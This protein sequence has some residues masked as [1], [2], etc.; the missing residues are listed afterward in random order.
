LPPTH[1]DGLRVHFHGPTSTRCTALP[2]RNA[3][4]SATRPTRQT[5]GSVGIAIPGTEVWIEDENGH[6]LGPDQVGEFGRARRH[7]MRGYWE[8]PKDTEKR[9]RLGPIPGERLCYT[10]DLFRMDAAATC[11]SSAARTTSS[12][13][14]E[15]KSRRRKSKNVLYRLPGVLE[16][17]V[18]GHP[19]P[20]CGHASSD[21]RPEESRTDTADGARALRSPSGEFHVPKYVEFRSELPKTFSGKINKTE[22]TQECAALPA[23]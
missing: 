15:K 10:G 19:T 12:N 6:R 17:A 7:V 4:S 16:A 1:I 2:K 9:F 5:P 18:V 8:A 21:H 11:I 22:L 20:I 14:V 23:S 3:R 13:V